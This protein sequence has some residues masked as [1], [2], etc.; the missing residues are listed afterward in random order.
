MPAKYYVC[1]HCNSQVRIRRWAAMGRPAP[2]GLEA[3]NALV[4]RIAAERSISVPEASHVVKIEG[5]WVP[6]AHN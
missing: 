4:A 3:R 5:L 6:H 1:E 2:K